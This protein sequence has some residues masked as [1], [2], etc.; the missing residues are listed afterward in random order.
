LGASPFGVYAANDATSSGSALV[1]QDVSSTGVLMDGFDGGG[2]LKL[3]VQDDGTVYAHGFVAES[4]TH[5]GQKMTTYATMSSVP[6]VEDFGEAQLTA[7]Q[8]YVS[9]KQAIAATIDARVNY[10]VFITPEGDTRGLY[11]TQ[12]TPA[13]FVV[14][15]SQGGRSDAAFSYRIVA[16][17]F[18]STTASLRPSSAPRPHLPNVGPF[19]K[20]HHVSKTGH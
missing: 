5:T 16:K 17:P 15:E 18:G 2:N 11:V 12:K 13:G 14:R 8:A 1:V 3:Q 4:D 6:N 7:G 19:A 9:L 10:M 20:L